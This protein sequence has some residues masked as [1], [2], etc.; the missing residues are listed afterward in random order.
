[1][2]S[3]ISYEEISGEG[4]CLV[5]DRGEILAGNATLLQKRH[6]AFETQESAHTI[7]YIAH[8][9]VY[10]GYICIGDKLKEGLNDY[11]VGLKQFWLS[12]F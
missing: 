7:V 8:N 2:E 3:L 4:V 9:G 1:M 10:A 11:L 12:D 6:I 5:C